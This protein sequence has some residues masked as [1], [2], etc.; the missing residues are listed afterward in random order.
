MF[1]KG[2][3]RG[4]GGAMTPLSICVYCREHTSWACG[5]CGR[6]DDSVHAHTQE[7]VQYAEAR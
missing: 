3:C 2:S 7:I 5:R 1:N 6:T 4:C